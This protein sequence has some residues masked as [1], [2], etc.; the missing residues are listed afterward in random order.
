VLTC[1][2]FLFRVAK[3]ISFLP[4]SPTAQVYVYYQLQGNAKACFGEDESY[5]GCIELSLNK[6]VRSK[7][8]MVAA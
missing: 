5:V 8:S 4:P 6:R 3:D 7:E 2:F 1:Y